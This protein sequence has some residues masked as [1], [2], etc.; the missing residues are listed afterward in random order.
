MNGNEN[1]N[2]VK[3]YEEFLNESSNSVP[4][5]LSQHLSKRMSSLLDPSPWRVF[6]KVLAIHSVVGFISLA[7]CHQFEVNPF[8]TERSLDNWF[9]AH[10][11]H[12]PCMIFCGVLF[13]GLSILAAG[14]FL[15]LEETRAL[16]RTGFPQTFALASISLLL[17]ATAGAEL[18]F[19]F[20]GLWLLGALVGGFV[21]LEAVWK[22]KYASIQRL[23]KA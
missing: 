19:A 20:A 17:F 6:G 5:D 9:M 18:A 10:V 23:Q 4:D 15:S 14:Y 11:G 1:R 3:D 12:E 2:W 7:F 21:A 16:R 13:V 8:N 22:F